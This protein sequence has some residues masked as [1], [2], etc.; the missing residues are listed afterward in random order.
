MATPSKPAEPLR[1]VDVKQAMERIA[2]A[3]DRE[4][5][6]DAITDYLRSTFGLGLILICRQGLALGWK[7]YS[8][9]ADATTL[10]SIAIPLMVPSMF[11]TS[12]TKAAPVIG[13]PPADGAVLQERLWKL[14]HCAPPSDVIVAPIVV[15]DRVINLVYA[16]AEPDARPPLAAASQI[17]ELCTAAAQSFMRLIQQGKKK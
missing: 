16:H 14:L 13:P 5:I 17:A 10:E 7:G 6:G 1:V 2:T 8:R 11:G 12:F 15:K 9:G 3:S 4:Q